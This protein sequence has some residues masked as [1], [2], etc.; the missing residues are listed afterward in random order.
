MLYVIRKW[1]STYLRTFDR[2]GFR[3]LLESIANWKK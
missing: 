1:F 2:D 3:Y